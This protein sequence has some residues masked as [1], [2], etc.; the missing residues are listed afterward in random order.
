MG[1]KKILVT[2]ATGFIGRNLIDSEEFGKYEIETLSLRESNI[3]EL[4]LKSVDVVIH[5]AGITQISKDHLSNYIFKINEDL[6]FELARKAKEQN[7]KNFIFLS[8]TKVFGNHIG[9]SEFSILDK[10]YPTDDY[11]RSK[12]NAELKLNQLN[13]ETFL[14]NNVRTP[15]VYGPSV[16]GNIISLI[17]L[18]DLGYPLP[19]DK[20]ENS[21]SMTYVGNL[22]AFI[23]KI[24]E[25]SIQGTHLVTDQSNLSTTELCKLILESLKK[26]TNLFKAPRFLIRILKIL[27]P[28]IHNR[29]YNSE[30][31]VP[32]STSTK[33]NSEY[34]INL[35]VQNYLAS[36]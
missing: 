3:S 26:D 17:K 19:L 14:V 35:M 34:G 22:I 33:F 24:I 18:L 30:V 8:T 12:L 1:K 31:F 6:T 23:D 36:K 25:E 4:N 29:L 15:V 16:K 10:C 7:V 20:I 27:K 21:R 2:G 28:G 9:K 32:T 5:L 11:G 13:S